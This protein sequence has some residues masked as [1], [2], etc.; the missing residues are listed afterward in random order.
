MQVQSKFS[1]IR[2]LVFNNYIR[3][4][5]SRFKLSKQFLIPLHIKIFN[6]LMVL[7]IDLKP[8]LD[9]SFTP[10]STLY[11]TT[12]Y[13]PRKKNPYPHNLIISSALPSPTILPSSPNLPLP[14][15]HNFVIKFALH[16][17]HILIWAWLFTLKEKSNDNNSA[18][19]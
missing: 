6:S 5:V 10:H 7:E 17:Y 11:F 8:S 16:L 2:Q 18:F 14:S 19:I 3:G 9:F 1:Y 12:L 15:P 13:Q 4:N